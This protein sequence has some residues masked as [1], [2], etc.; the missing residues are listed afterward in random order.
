MASEVRRTGKTARRL[1]VSCGVSNRSTG[2]EGYLFPYT[3][4]SQ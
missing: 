4:T 3:V 2:F 1:Q